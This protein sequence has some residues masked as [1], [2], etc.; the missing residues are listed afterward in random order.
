[1]SRDDAT[2]FFSKV[3]SSNQERLPENCIMCHKR[4]LPQLAP[5]QQTM[6]GTELFR[7]SPFCNPCF[8]S[9][10]P[11]YREH[12]AW[13]RRSALALESLAFNFEV[14]V[15]ELAAVAELVRKFSPVLI[16]VQPDSAGEFLQGT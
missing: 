2:T 3:T 5:G 8:H 15:A 13:S 1:M 7:E 9:T 6:P 12:L 10:A 16:N 14:S 4:R 11:Y